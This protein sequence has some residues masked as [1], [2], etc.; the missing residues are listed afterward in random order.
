MPPKAVVTTPLT[1]VITLR[2]G[3]DT[4]IS[5]NDLQVVIRG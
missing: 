2:I 1:A 5:D 3:G 4:S